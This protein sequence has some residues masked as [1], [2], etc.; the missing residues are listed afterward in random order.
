[1]AKADHCDV[2][3][4]EQSGI[5]TGRALWI[6]RRL[7]DVDPDRAA[8]PIPS[9][10][11]TPRQNVVV[12]ACSREG[13]SD[14]VAFA[15]RCDFTIASVGHDGD[16]LVSAVCLADLNTELVDRFSQHDGAAI[17]A[18]LLHRRYQLILAL[19][20]ALSAFLGA[21]QAALGGARWVGVLLTAVGLDTAAIAS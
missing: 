13:V 21:L 17:R 12:W 20:V 16:E 18:Q 4:F 10:Q 3:N 2:D 14:V 6:A 7:G 8:S 15:V 19:G 11:R 1:M 5:G 9:T